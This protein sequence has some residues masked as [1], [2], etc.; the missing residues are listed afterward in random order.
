MR[1]KLGLLVFIKSV[2]SRCM[3][4]HRI[5]IASTIFAEKQKESFVGQMNYGKSVFAHPF[6]IY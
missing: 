1:K 6:H 2:P 3:T 4:A 5:E